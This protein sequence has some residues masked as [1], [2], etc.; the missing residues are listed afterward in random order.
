MFGNGSS[1]LSSH[2]LAHASCNNNNIRIFVEFIAKMRKVRFFFSFQVRQDQQ[3]PSPY[4]SEL[5]KLSQIAFEVGSQTKFGSFSFGDSLQWIRQQI[6]Y[7]MIGQIRLSAAAGGAAE[8]NNCRAWYSRHTGRLISFI[9]RSLLFTRWFFRAPSD[10]MV[11]DGEYICVKI[12]ISWLP[13]N[14]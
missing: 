4:S 3:D 1:S 12:G 7:N 14:K 6:K 2:C 5:M 11:H 13:L 10:A 8:P 9:F